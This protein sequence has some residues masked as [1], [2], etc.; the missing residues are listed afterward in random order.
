M[1]PDICFEIFDGGDLIRI[2]PLT[3]KNQNSQ[4]DWDKNWL[5]AKIT[6]K[7]GVFSGQFIADFMTTDF[8][9]FKRELKNLDKD[10]KGTAKFDPVEGQLVINIVGDG[11]G[12]FE[13]QCTA[14]DN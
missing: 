7:G 9:L 6:V 1:H 3:H 2:E 12:H 10:F 8:E 11:L 4:N 14:S 5:Q 13:V